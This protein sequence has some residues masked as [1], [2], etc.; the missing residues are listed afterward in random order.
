[1]IKTLT[2][3]NFQ[4][5]ILLELNFQDGLNI[6]YGH[7]DSGKSSI[8]RALRWILF[9]DFSSTEARKQGTKETSVSVL[10]D[11]DIKVSRIK[12]NS[13]NAYEVK[14]GKDVKRFDAIGKGIPEEIQKIFGME[15]FEVDGTKINLNIAEQLSAP[16]LLGKEY[17]STFR[18]KLFN[19]LTG[20]DLQDKLFKDLNKEILGFGRDISATEQ[21]TETQTKEL[22]VIKVEQV[23]CDTL[24]DNLSNALLF[25]EDL[26]EKKEAYLSLSKR[27]TENLSALKTAKAVKTS[28]KDIDQSK[29][30]ALQANITAL[31]ALKQGLEKARKLQSSVLEVEA[32]LDQTKA[33]VS[34]LKT[35]ELVFD[36]SYVKIERLNQLRFIKEDLAVVNKKIDE[37][38][39][40]DKRLEHSLT[41]YEAQLNELKKKFV[42]CPVCDKVISKDEIE[43]LKVTL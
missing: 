10:F 8:V 22:E 41:A 42:T 31:E 40:S 18:A 27:L 43:K 20:N 6:I 7:T 39:L 2:L 25:C 24:H 13:V 11:T 35:P 30:D 29:L 12:S 9:D 17:P 36:D 15:L 4:K 26:N 1:M 37:A 16:F 38:L 3:K 34:R 33:E 23:K 28:I 5:H 14:Q 21:L 32:R 19:Q